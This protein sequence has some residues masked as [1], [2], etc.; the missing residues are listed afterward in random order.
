[1]PH[2]AFQFAKFIYLSVNGEGGLFARHYGIRQL[3][4][5]IT[6]RKRNALTSNY[7]TS[8]STKMLLDDLIHTNNSKGESNSCVTYSKDKHDIDR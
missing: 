5:H 3:L 7:K 4:P 2:P 6:S 8:R 1:M